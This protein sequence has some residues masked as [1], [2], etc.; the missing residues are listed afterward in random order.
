[1]GFLTEKCTFK[2]FGS[3][4]LSKCDKFSCNNEDLDDFFTNQCDDYSNEL[5]GKSYCFSLDA[6]ERQIVCAFTVSNDSIKTNHLTRKKKNKLNRKIPNVKRTVTYPSALIGRLG[7][8]ARFWGNHYGDELM[9][10]IKFWFIDPKNKT[11][12]RY[13]V[14]D[15]YNTDRAITYYQRNGFDFLFDNETD[16]KK[17]TGLRIK[18]SKRQQL[19]NKVLRLFKQKEIVVEKL[20]TRLMYFDL[21]VL[22]A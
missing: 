7:V 3:S 13:I 11:G 1:M 22:K 21:I 16:E 12:C 19:Y 5:L 2:E 18:L 14:V 8:N 20:H 17:Y 4:L 6:D 9:D 15:S 10:F